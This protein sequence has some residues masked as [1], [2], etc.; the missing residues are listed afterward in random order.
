MP[1]NDEIVNLFI[2]SPCHNLQYHPGNLRR[3]CELD[4]AVKPVT[5]NQ[6]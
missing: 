5:L 4:F 3:L 1:I 2:A 6:G